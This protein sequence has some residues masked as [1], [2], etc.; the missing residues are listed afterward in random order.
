MNN[1]EFVKRI[2]QIGKIKDIREAF[3]EYPI[4]EEEHKGKIE[5]YL[6]VAED[7]EKYSY[8]SE[9]NVG[10]IVYVKEYLYK[11][12]EKGRNH[13]FVIIGK[14][15]LAVPIEYFGMLISS[16]TYKL[17][18]KTND[19]LKRNS[20]NNLNKDSII[21]LDEIY[22]IKE[23]AINFKIGKVDDEKIEEYKRRYLQINE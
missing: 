11:N 22:L 16:K 6:S 14:D 1:E 12:G 21:K 5:S 18:Y 19:F 4:E 10:D 2:K 17:K 7:G 15:N 8:A 23:S 13:L 20:V 9:Y 3:I